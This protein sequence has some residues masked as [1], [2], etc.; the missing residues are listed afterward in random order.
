MKEEEIKELKHQARRDSIKEGMFATIKGSLFDSYISPFAIAINSSNSLIA[1]MSSFTGL[2]GPISQ[3][4]SS[5]LM[6]KYS[7]KKIVVS[8]VLLE[9]L[10]ILPI[11]IIA[12]LFYKGI[13]TQ[14]LPLILLITFSIYVILANISG[15]AWFSWMGDIIDEEYRGRW[16]AKRNLILGFISVILAIG[17]SF[18]LDIFKQRNWEMQ[19]FI[20]LFLVSFLGRWISK[21]IFKK[22][23]EPKIEL[24]EGYYFSFFQFI[25]KAQENNFGR[26]TLFRTFLSF[27]GSIFAPFLAVYLLKDLEFSYTIYM[28]IIFST[29][30]FSLITMELWGKFADEYGNYKTILLTSLII[31]II[32]ILWFLNESPIY[33]IL[34]PSLIGGIAWAGFNLSSGNFI[35]DNVSIPRRG[36]IISYFNLLN[37]IGIFLGAGLGAI[38]VKIIPPTSINP[39]FWIFLVSAI[40][41]MIIVF[42]WIPKIKEVRKISQFKGRESL[43]NI[44]L[45]QAKP[46]I[47]EGVYDL[48]SIKK[49]FT[50]K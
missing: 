27:A 6:E 19:G 13:I 49:Y 23:Y 30:I 11:I 33:L 15:P 16:F 42:I 17:A 1:M 43:S 37:G 38:L 18:F 3:L 9:C 41:R 45:K 35:Y 5:R 10:S 24:K 4:F 46:A 47:I 40:L 28:I 14:F 44:I 32:P 7:R 2:L 25:S 26:F 36:L 29:T 20:V 12:F 8:S 39:L 50:S 34:V 31:P 21:E 48:I 22:Q